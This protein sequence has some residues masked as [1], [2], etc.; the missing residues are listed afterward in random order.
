MKL[1]FAGTPDFASEALAALYEAGHDI[2]AVITMPDKPKGRKGEPVP[3]P[4]KEEALKHG[5]LVMQPVNLKSDEVFEE[6]KALEP[7]VIVVSAYGNLVP[8]R[9]LELP[10]YGCVNEHASLLPAYRGAAPI[11]WAI[12]DGCEKTGVTIM[13]MDK[14]LDT[15][16]MLSFCEVEIAKDETAGSLFDKLSEAGAKLLVRTLEEIENGTITGGTP[17]PE[18]STTAYARMITKADGQIDWTR[19]AAELERFIRGMDPWPAAYTR[20]NGK[21]LKIWKADVS[22]GETGKEP[23]T[24]IF[25]DKGRVSVQTG[26]GLLVFREVQLEGKKRMECGSFL[27]G[28]AVKEGTVLG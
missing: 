13:Q 1:I 2:K 15:G 24:V 19:S 3:T 10:K 16:D 28:N 9:I 12:L 18:R 23:G 17:Q 5:T 22:E 6:I 14:G 25:S 8:E 27:C 26:S 20:L 21:T 11:Q 4:V 7:E